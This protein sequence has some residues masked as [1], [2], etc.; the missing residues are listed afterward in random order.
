MITTA[1]FD[2]LSTNPKATMIYIY[3]VD[4][5]A[6]NSNRKIKSMYYNIDKSSDLATSLPTAFIVLN[7]MFSSTI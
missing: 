7:R 6:N 4:M 1:N 3:S 2:L 5:L